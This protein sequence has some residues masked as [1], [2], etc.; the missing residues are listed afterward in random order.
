M[1]RR[2]STQIFSLAF[3]DCI[4]CGF[5]AIILIFVLSLSQ[6]D[7]TREETIES[8]RRIL[9][10][11]IASLAKLNAS[12]EDIEQS[13]ARVATMVVDARL[14]NDTMHALLDE[15]QAQL[16]HE[17]KGQSAML[18]DL[19]DLKKEI[20]ARQKKKPDALLLANVPPAPIG[21]PME[22]NYICFVVDTSGSMRDPNTG[23]LWG[24]AFRKF[25]EVLDAYP[26]VKGIQILDGDGRFI[27]GR[28]QQWMADSPEMR[29]AIKRTL[30]RY[31]IFSESNP[32]AGIFRALRTLP[33]PANPDM[34]MG[35]YLFGDEFTGVADPVIRQMDLLNPADANGVRRVV[36]NA[37]LFPTTIRYEFSMGNTGLKLSNL[38][39]ELCYQ[40]GGAMIAL[41][42]L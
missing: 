36:I 37:V 41:Q 39:R 18:V 38:M 10:A 7:K 15:L 30:R 22:S 3:L 24:I 8:L 11:Q 31:E 20:A 21:V 40:H 14:R 9:A 42:D 17:K 28:D 13:N 25:E 29:D 32:T 6:Q 2:R 12:K 27:M 16:Q 33:D 35:I 26:S 4:C 19:D 1:I 23:A 34:H 5:G